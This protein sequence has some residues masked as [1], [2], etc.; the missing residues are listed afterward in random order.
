M[1]LTRAQKEVQLAELKDKFGTASSVLFANYIGLTVAQVSDLR[2]KLRKGGAEMKVA[3]KTLM[4]IAAK[5]K[6]LP[7]PEDSMMKNAVACIFSFEDP[8][9]GA[10]IAFKFSKEFPQVAFL[11]GIFEGKLLSQT[12][13]KELAKMPSR[14]VLLAIFAGMLQSPLRS[15]AS[16]C[17]SP[18][19]G[20]ARALSEVAKKKPSA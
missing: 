19:T 8:L 5:E 10:Q 12:Q 2:K 4:C 17:N 3:K 7:E 20:F 18:L 14:Q 9:A 15:F 13:A 16:I 6:G 11:G 1:A